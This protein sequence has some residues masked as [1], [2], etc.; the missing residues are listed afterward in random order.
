MSSGHLAE[1]QAGEPAG[2]GGEAGDDPF[3]GDGRNGLELD[4]EVVLGLLVDAEVGILVAP[5]L[6]ADL[7][8]VD[9]E[10]QEPRGA[11]VGAAPL[12]PAGV[13]GGLQGLPGSVRPTRWR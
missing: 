8:P 4:A 7:G 6:G 9:V 12:Q 13:G 3:P 10:F 11:R 1:Q 5:H 2:V